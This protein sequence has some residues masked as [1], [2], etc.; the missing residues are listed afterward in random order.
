MASVMNWR[1]IDAYKV[2][3]KAA[4][5]AL[6]DEANNILVEAVDEAPI[7]TGALRRSGKVVPDDKETKVYVSFGDDVVNYAI[8][9]HETPYY[10]HPRGGKWKYLEDP[11]KRNYSKARANIKY[12]ILQAL[13]DAR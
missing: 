3:Q 13:K 4:M 2:A 6:T 12:R 11:F 7:D 8:I 9:Q 10:N 1:G 5:E